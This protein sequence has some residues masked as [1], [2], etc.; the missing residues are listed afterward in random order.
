MCANLVHPTVQMM[1]TTKTV[2]VVGPSP[3]PING[4]SVATEYVCGMLGRGAYRVVHLDTAD[5]RGLGNVGKLD[6]GNVVL[7][8][9]HGARFARLLLANRGAIVYVP[10]A[11]NT[12]GFLRDCLFL[13]PSR[14]LRRRTVIH[15]HGSA[16]AEFYKTSSRVMRA[17]V[18]LALAK[19][20]RAIVLGES[21]AGIFDGILP[22]DRIRVVPNG[23]EDLF[24]GRELGKLGTSD[25]PFTVLYLSALTEGKGFLDLLDAAALLGEPG[26]SV[27]IKLA[28]ELVSQSARR[29]SVEFVARLPSHVEVEFLGPVGLEDKV[30][31]LQA[32]DVFVFPPRQ[33]EGLPYS[34]LE[35]M[36]AGLPV[37]TTD[38]GCIAEVIRDGQEGFVLQRG[39]VD[40]LADALERLRMNRELRLQMG[41]RARER[42]R[43]EYSIGEWE[44]RM[45]AVFSELDHGGR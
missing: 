39:R 9:R 3:P 1:T 34:I 30:A 12:M 33:A 24:A 45:L 8:L 27:K 44:E 42:W 11:Q 13:L 31:L 37:V 16:F 7:A 35:A 41:Q 14:L 23:I 5:R 29:R 10:I 4:M 28:G 38:S 15:L 25:Q 6:F 26:G 36:C 43:R 19:V 22:R 2:V 32:A 20:A 21:T 17:L 18:R 40:L